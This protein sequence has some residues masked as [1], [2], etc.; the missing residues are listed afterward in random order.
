MRTGTMR[1][2]AAAL[3]GILVAAARAGDPA[4]EPSLRDYLP[5][6]AKARAFDAAEAQAA[7]AL[8]K[9]PTLAAEA[10]AAG[11]E[12]GDT[13]SALRAKFDRHPRLYAFFAAQGLSKDDAV[14]LPLTLMNACSVAQM[15]SLQAKMADVVSPQQVAFCKAHLAELQKLKFFGDG[16]DAP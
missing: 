1:Q 15:P 6:M 4:S 12:A 7:A 16:D 5:T 9:D 10:D 13:A 3:L 2:A 8:K 11:D 14:L